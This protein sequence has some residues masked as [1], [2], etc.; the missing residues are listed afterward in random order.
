MAEINPANV[1]LYRSLKEERTAIDR[2]RQAAG[3]SHTVPRG[4]IGLALSGGGI[5]SATFALGALQAL[6]REKK[7]ASFDYLST[8][9]GG[10][11]IG[12][13]LSA[14]IQREGLKT[15]QDAM[16]SAESTLINDV[17]T[18]NEPKQIAWLRR[19]SN[20][21]APR[22]G[23]F[24]LDSL[25]LAATWLRN[26]VLNLVVLLGAIC[27]LFAIPY[28]M[29]DLLQ[30]YEPNPRAFGFAAAWLGF[31]LF[32]LVGYNLWHQGL[33]VGR[34]RNWL[35]SAPG[36]VWSVIVPGL[37]AACCAPVWL[38]QSNRNPVEDGTLAAMYM[39][40]LLVVLLL[41]WLVRDA[42]IARAFPVVLA[43][44][45]VV[46]LIAGAVAL[47]AGFA[48]LAGLLEIWRGLGDASA[49][50]HRHLATIAFGPPSVLAALGIAT[51][52]FTGL[53]G[54]VFFER[55]REW[56]SRLNAWFLMLA[57]LWL[58]WGL[59]AFFSL[60]LVAWVSEHLGAWSSLIGTGWIG[61]L[62]ASLLL[63]QPEGA[64]QKARVRIDTALNAA[65]S[66]FVIGL[67]IVT[68]VAVSA[69]AL[70]LFRSS[71][72][73]ATVAPAPALSFELHTAKDTVDYKVSAVKHEPPDLAPT[74][75]VHAY[76]IGSFAQVSAN[77]TLLTSVWGWI[78][79]LAVVVLLFAFRVDINKF[80]L[81]NMYKNR[82]VRCYL[83]ASNKRRNEQ[84]FTGLDDHDDLTLVQLRGQRPLHIVNT[85]LNISQGSNLAWQERKAASFSFTPWYCGFSLAATQGDSTSMK[86][87]EQWRQRGYCPTE[88][89]ASKD[90]EDPGFK[91][92][93]AM[94]TSGAAVSPNMGRATHP[95]RA[96]VLT[97]FNV[98]LGRWSPNPLGTRWSRP[99]PW[100]GIIPLVQELLGYSNERRSFVYLSDGGH[101]DNL[102]LYELIRR[103]CSVIVVVDAGA[104][105]RR[106]FGDLGESIR[107]CR[108]DFGVNIRFPALQ[109]AKPDDDMCRE[110][111]YA[112]GTVEYG[113]GIADGR[114]LLIKPTM[115][116]SREEPM[117]VLHYAG[118]D[119]TF[120]HQTTG[121]QFFDES[122]FESYRQ[123]GAFITGKCLAQHKWLLRERS[124]GP[125]LVS[126]PTPKEEPL[127]V[128]RKIH[129]ALIFMGL[130]KKKA[131]IPPRDGS[132]ADLLLLIL[133][134]STLLLVTLQLI[135][136]ATLQ[137]L[138]GA[139][140]WSVDSCTSHTKRLLSLP[141]AR[142][143]LATNPLFWFLQVDN[144]FVA[145]YTAL[146]VCA[147]V[148]A[149][150]DGTRHP[151]RKW[152]KYLLCALALFGATAD[153]CENFGL[154]D[155]IS[156]TSGTSRLRA[157]DIAR[158]TIAKFALLGVLLVALL[159]AL[160]SI[161]VKFARRWDLHLRKPFSRN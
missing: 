94:A 92:G 132:L 30:R 39:G 159:I 155:I 73:T 128:T 133:L 85:T 116:P 76:D 64:S 74:F 23:I 33:P 7:L 100:L 31:V 127:C 46:Y 99:S 153:Y 9:S 8:V 80:S 118:K 145:V 56:W 69:A 139:G 3:E 51:S 158:L 63:R 87:E 6:A 21:L 142:G 122:Q 149:L 48:A 20:Y 12:S 14:W 111:G 131:T 57:G 147:F 70:A 5:R 88:D 120:P 82:L 138:G 104:D 43:K 32:V 52:V 115:C 41:A 160:P 49:A 34:R 71:T 156:G 105:S 79:G 1:D 141:G 77:R 126:Q 44:K 72:K 117:D 114:I 22:V 123:L 136:M 113:N 59:L 96:F 110:T 119:S 86:V 75:R 108:I 37:I 107:K 35:I 150:R 4:D 18:A 29:L 90:I 17:P 98:R 129:H 78:A 62:F 67:L 84:P 66:V 144:L 102:G 95:A 11:Y 15:V 26:F 106:Q 81:H 151:V 2:E 19:Y 42:W 89:Y 109:N 161:A 54:R 112:M 40:A 93:M 148:V 97:L 143:E 146:F 137:G 47:V 10:G 154:L 65:A 134:A 24:S 91:L 140:C 58:A 13:W 68:A 28:G 61:S 36:V 45:L 125:P 27:L 130:R 157:D 53:V 135:S 83:G 101:F 121:D 124:V 60:P 16:G 55:S 38:F 25:T 50:T 152:T 103:Q